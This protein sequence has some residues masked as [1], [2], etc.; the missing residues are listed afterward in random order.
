MSCDKKYCELMKRRE[1]LMSEL[2]DK[3][4]SQQR[5]KSCDN[6][7]VYMRR[8]EDLSMLPEVKIDLN[9]VE[10]ASVRCRKD[11]MLKCMLNSELYMR[12]AMGDFVGL[13]VGEEN[14]N[15]NHCE[16]R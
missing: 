3:L 13:K 9:D 4:M 16:S 12:Y 7:P 5:S 2:R 8:P 11:L 10:A 14:N 15:A 6:R 1:S